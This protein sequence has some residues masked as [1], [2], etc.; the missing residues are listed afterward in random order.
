MDQSRAGTFSSSNIW[1]LL[2]KDRSGKGLGAP[3]LKYLKQV[4][5]ERELGRAISVEHEAR[6]TSWGNLCEKH[7]FQIL[8]TSYRYFAKKRF[9]HPSLPWT[10]CPDAVKDDTT[11]DIKCPTIEVFCDKIKVLN[12][13]IQKYKEEYPEDYWQHISNSVLLNLNGYDIKFFEPIIYCPYKK[14]LEKIREVASGVDDLIEQRKYY[15]VISS[16]DSELPWLPNDSS[17]KDLNVFKFEIP[18]Q[19]QDFLTSVIEG[20]S[21]LLIR[22]AA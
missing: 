18:K 6:T 20:Y 7:V 16:D 8:D 13:G 9:Y 19:D 12:Q 11:S 17:Y 14:D 3:G 22:K 2:S 4:N 1:K 5:Y 10:G 21:K 15:W